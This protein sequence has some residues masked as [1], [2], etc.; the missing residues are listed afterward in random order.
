MPGWLSAF[1]YAA[2]QAKQLDNPFLFIF[3]EFPYAAQA[4]QALPSQLQ[5]AI[6]HHFTQTNAC[7]ILCGSNEGFMES[8]VLGKKSPLYGRRTGQIHL[9]PFDYFEAAQMSHT[10]S[11]QEQVRYYATFGGTPY[12]LAQLDTSLTYEEN[13]HRL[14]FSSSGLLYAEPSMLLRQE[15]REPALY[16]AILSAVANG[17]TTPKTIADQSGVALTSVGKYLKTLVN[18]HIL[19]RKTPFGT[20]VEGRKALYYITDPFFAFWYRF[21][22]PAV[23]AIELGAGAAAAREVTTGQSLSTFEGHQFETITTQWLARRNTQEGL[24]FLATEFGSWWGTDPQ[25]KEQVDIDVIAANAQR[26]SIIAGE[27]KWRE[28]F[29]ETETLKTLEHRAQLIPGNWDKS[30]LYLFSKKP[31]SSATQNKIK[32]NPALR[33]ITLKE[34]Y[35]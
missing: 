24:P 20:K 17:A 9:K 14:M 29:N 16:N 11:P 2:Q 7:I 32:N 26:R 13:V 4:N 18:L 25:A 8:E 27:C 12:Y 15:L 28:N 33:S 30:Y 31:L 35:S 5:I 19:A 34:M 6:D 3:D 10:S 22:S 23:G 1:E 21:V